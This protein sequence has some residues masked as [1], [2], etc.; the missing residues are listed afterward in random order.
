MKK[1][2]LIVCLVLGLLIAVIPEARAL[3]VTIDRISGYYTGNG[4]EFNIEPSDWAGITGYDT[5]ALVGDGFESFCLER[6][7]YVTIPGT[8]NAVFNSKAVM[9]G[10]PPNGDPISIGT[11]YLYNQFA[12]GQLTGYNYTVG[13]GRAVDAGALQN[14]IW[15]LEGEI[16]WD[17]SNEFIALL[18]GIPDYSSEA[19]ATA[20]NNGVIPVAVLN[21]YNSNGSLAQDQLVRV[22][23][24]GILILL[25]IALSAVGLAAR[26]YRF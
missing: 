1:L 8:Y 22:P 4:G 14:A 21:L 16:T 25:G 5:K 2:T 10:N 26:R 15:M 13:S 7:E 9:G 23:E 11:A 24:P 20:N 6:S 18:L 12:L 3:S 17:S 19:L